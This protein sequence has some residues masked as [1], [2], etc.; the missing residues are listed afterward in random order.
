VRRN[1]LPQRAINDFLRRVDNDAGALAAHQDALKIGAPAPA[2][3]AAVRTI[4]HGL[5]GAS[6]IFGFPAISDA[7]AALEET[8]VSEP[9]DSAFVEKLSCA[10]D[11]LLACI[12]ANRAYQQEPLVVGFD[13]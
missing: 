8:I 2:E 11:R 5:A 13:A 7:A 9:S 6:G 3:L 10:I 12:E 1:V 4:A